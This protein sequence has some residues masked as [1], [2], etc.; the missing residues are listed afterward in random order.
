MYRRTYSSAHWNIGGIESPS[1]H[2]DLSPSWW[3]WGKQ[4]FIDRPSKILNWNESNCRFLVRTFQPLRISIVLLW[5]HWRDKTCLIWR[6]PRQRMFWKVYE[7]YFSILNIVHFWTFARWL[8]VAWF[9]NGSSHCPCRHGIRG[10]FGCGGRCKSGKA[11]HC[12][13]GSFHAL[14]GAVWWA[15]LGIQ[16]KCISIRRPCP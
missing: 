3:Q 5:L 4:R 1:K 9:S 15:A 7:I 2:L 12:Q 6:A 14:Y 13:P 11:V 10:I 16:G 8:C